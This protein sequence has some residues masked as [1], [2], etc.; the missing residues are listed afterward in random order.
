VR[1]V[2]KKLLGN[3]ADVDA[4]AAEGAGLGDADFRAERCG[5]AASPYAARPA[6]DGEKIE[7]ERQGATSGS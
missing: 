6:A 7:I 4:G 1:S 5:D 3:A 2:G